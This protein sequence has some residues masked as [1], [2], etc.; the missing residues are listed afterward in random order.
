MRSSVQVHRRWAM[1]CLCWLQWCTRWLRRLTSVW[2]NRAGGVSSSTLSAMTASG[3]IRAPD[4]LLI[5]TWTR[6][7]WP[8]S[9]SDPRLMVTVIFLINSQIETVTS[10]LYKFIKLRIFIYK[11]VDFPTTAVAFIGYVCHLTA[12]K[13]CSEEGN[14]GC[15]NV[16]VVFYFQRHVSSAYRG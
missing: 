11:V 9:L 5:A 15:R 10:K 14:I 12:N 4:I 2:W 1:R 13:K 6:A 16:I 8:H 7:S 3:R